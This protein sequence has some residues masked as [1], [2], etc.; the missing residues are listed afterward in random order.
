M[1]NFLRVILS[2]ILLSSCNSESLRKSPQHSENKYEKGKNLTQQFCIS[3]H[4]PN[5]SIGVQT[6]PPLAM[7]KDVY[8]KSYPNEKEFNTKMVTWLQD[9][10]HETA[11]LK[12]SV[13]KYGLMPN[14]N[15]SKKQLDPI[16]KYIYSNALKKPNW[17][18][19]GE[20]EAQILT[21]ELDSMMKMV[22]TTKKALGKNL[23]GQLKKNGT[24]KALEFCNINA[25]HITDSISKHYNVKIQRV[26]DKP[27]NTKNKALSSDL[28]IIEDY[29]LDLKQGTELKPQ[30]LTT[31]KTN[32]MLYAPIITNKMC[33]QCH[34]KPKIGIKED[35]INKIDLLYP[36]DKAKDYSEQELRGVWKISLN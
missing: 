14:L 20:G 35:I 21:T 25:L 1:Y 13:E 5:M 22:Y 4:N 10:N 24:L 16:V 28:K 15:L 30:I 7:I 11:L 19:L 18:N 8:L 2:I 26:S 36:N 29:K 6:A 23:M 3:C 27:R 32:K 17:Y 12:R 31:L 34:G 33:L 9:P